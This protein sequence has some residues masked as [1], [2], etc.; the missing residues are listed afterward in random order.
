MTADKNKNASEVEALD[1]SPSSDD[2]LAAPVVAAPSTASNPDSN[3]RSLKDEMEDTIVGT[4]LVGRYEIL[5]CLS[6]QPASSLY[7]A[8]HLL[9][10]RAVAIRLLTATDIQSLKRF[11][12]EAKV[13]SS[14]NHPNIITVLDFGVANGRP[15]LVTDYLAGKTL[16]EILKQQGRLS[17]SM[18]LDI[19]S[20]VCDAAAYAH[21]QDLLLRC[22]KPS[23]IFV[24]DTPELKDFV[25][26]VEFGISERYLEDGEE[27]KNLAN[28]G[29]INGDPHYLS[30]ESCLAVKLDAKS[31][32]FTIGCV[33]YELLVGRP[34]CE[35]KSA[36]EVMHRQLTKVPQAVREAA[37]TTDIPEAVERV[38]MRAIEKD[39]DQRYSTMEAMWSEIEVYKHGAKQLRLSQEKKSPPKKDQIR[40]KKRAMRVLGLSLSLFLGVTLG[41]AI[42]PWKE[43][44]FNQQPKSKPA[45]TT[46]WQDLNRQGEEA[47]HRGEYHEAESLFGQALAR[48]GGFEP[49]DLR[50]AETLNNLGTLYF[51]LDLYPEA[52]NAIKRA[53]AIRQKAGA[54]T[55]LA[56]DSLNDLG[57]IYLTQ[58]KLNE[59]KVLVEKALAIREKNLKPDDE[60]IASSLQSMASVYHKE[61]KLKE[62][63]AALKRALY[64]RKRSLGANHLDVATTYNSL[65]VQHQLAGDNGEARQC[66][67]HARDV[68]EKLYGDKHPAMAD[69]L[70]GLGTLEFVEDNQQ[71]AEENF[72]KALSIRE[73]TL[74]DESY[75]VAE[76]L[77]CLA[78][79][80]EQKSKFKESE[81]LLRRAIAIDEQAVGANAQ[82]TLRV[83]NSLVRVLKKMGKRDEARRLERRIMQAK[84]AEQAEKP[85]KS[86]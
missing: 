6:K 21:K 7:K 8:R 82:E 31:D 17:P 40:V 86:E 72:S 11:Q 60:D 32:V 35:G 29:I 71:K 81:A 20:Q 37:G 83:T 15:Y 63:M 10:D 38:V 85:L 33:M 80:K 3:D 44:I 42:E 84:K 51:N 25:K 23:Q 19:I 47:F 53:L 78:I 14:L 30:P 1:A 79:L 75:R 46:S 69:S 9:M 61:G 27:V 76:V 39:P 64:I 67:E 26:I 16:A 56:A 4:T 49:N 77:S 2:N 55:L 50:I 18:T 5:E 58:G 70:L 45:V 66:Y 43:S 41:I 22:L 57:M 62:A 74:G 36:H 13:A 24:F 12:V 28:K 34:P 52:E 73:T 59:G 65:A 54:D 68:I 48:S